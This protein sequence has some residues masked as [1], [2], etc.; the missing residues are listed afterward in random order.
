MSRSGRV[1]VSQADGDQIPNGVQVR[2]DASAEA[3]KK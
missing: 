1:A 3:K 2:Q